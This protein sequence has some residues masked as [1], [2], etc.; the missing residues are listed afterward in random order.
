MSTATPISHH[1]ISMTAVAAAFVAALA[2]AG[3][4]VAE[5]HHSSPTPTTTHDGYQY[6]VYSISRP[7]HSGVQ[8]GMP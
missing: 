1:P 4:A 7:W 2:F 3:A 8:P 5:Q 6:P